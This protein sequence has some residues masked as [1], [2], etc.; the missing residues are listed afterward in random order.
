[1]KR[2]VVTGSPRSGTTW[3]SAA[4]RSLR[5]SC[6]HEQIFTPKGPNWSA[7]FKG[8]VSWMAQPHVPGLGKEVVV[9]HQVRDPA[10]AIPSIMARKLLDDEGTE[11]KGRMWG[12]YQA[13]VHKHAPECFNWP[14]GIQRAAAFWCMWNEPLRKLAHGFKLEDVDEAFLRRFMG[15]IEYELPADLKEEDLTRAVLVR[16]APASA[17]LNLDDLTPDLRSRVQNLAFELGY[18]GGRSR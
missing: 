4:L 13:Y 14:Q 15:W 7:D 2:F 10:Y 3:F 18:E 5:V 9:I 11:S 17:A 1:M 6:G 8:D 12:I 16:T